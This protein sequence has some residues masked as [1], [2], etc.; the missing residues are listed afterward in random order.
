M[1]MGFLFHVSIPGNTELLQPLGELT[2]RVVEYAGYRQEVARELAAA[3]TEGAAE[4]IRQSSS[5]PMPIDLHFQTDDER[6]EVVLSYADRA[7]PGASPGR[8]RSFTCDREGNRNVCRMARDL[9]VAP[10]S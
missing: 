6:F 1:S 10:G 7:E 2:A 3:I 5:A 8:L 4:A 9:P